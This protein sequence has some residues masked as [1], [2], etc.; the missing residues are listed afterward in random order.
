MRPKEAWDSHQGPG[1]GGSRKRAPQS[2]KGNANSFTT[3][4][5]SDQPSGGTAFFSDGSSPMDANDQHQDFEPPQLRAQTRPRAS[6][7]HDGEAAHARGPMKESTAAAALQRAIQS[8]P[9]HQRSLQHVNTTEE[10]LTPKPIRRILFPSPT[11]KE[12]EQEQR[13]PAQASGSTEHSRNLLNGHGSGEVDP[14]NKENVPPPSDID[15]PDDVND[16]L[17]PRSVTPT[18]SGKSKPKPFK[19]PKRSTTPDPSHPST[20]DFFSSAAR[21]LLRP[22]STP[23]H[24]SC[25]QGEHPPLSDI[26]PF[27]AHVNAILSDVQNVSPTHSN[28]DFPALPSLSN[29]PGRVRPDFDFSHFDPQDLLS[30]DVPMASSPPLGGWFGVYEDPAEKETDWWTQ[31]GFLGSS[32]PKVPMEKSTA[33]AAALTV[34]ENGHATVDVGPL[35][36]G[37]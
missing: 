27:T 8:S 22:H 14:S 23:K 16:G 11:Q 26:S 12:Q 1:P 3:Q 35:P 13:S 17:P 20:G 18:P 21:A 9:V 36:I 2:R 32:P 31:Y 24:T 28:F 29:T 5:T 10:D 6:S 7:L 15:E 4:A 19:T 30:T 37:G 34:D 25:R 33:K